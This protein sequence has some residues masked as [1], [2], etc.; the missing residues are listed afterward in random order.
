VK[1]AARKTTQCCLIRRQAES[2]N[3]LPSRER[4]DPEERSRRQFLR[5]FWLSKC[6]YKRLKLKTANSYQCQKYLTWELPVRFFVS[7]SAVP[8]LLSGFFTQKKWT[9]KGLH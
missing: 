3:A 8:A 9:V 4:T 1:R 5:H 2:F 7:G 6:G